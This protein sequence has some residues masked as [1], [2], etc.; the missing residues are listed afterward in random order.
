MNFQ[1]LKDYLDFYL[2][3]LGIPGSDTVIYKDHEQ[4]F[5]YQSGYD[6]L[7]FRTPVRSNAL[8]HVYSISKISTAVAATQLIERGELLANDPVYA[9]I[10]EFKNTPVKVMRPDGSFDLRPGENTMQIKH[11]LSM[12]AGMS[13]N[14]NSSGIL[15]VKERTE[16]R[17]PTLET[18]RAMAEEP[19]DFEPGTNYQYSLCLDV[20]GG[21]V[22]LVSGMSLGEYMKKNIFDPLGMTQ[23]SFKLTDERLDMMA[24]KYDYDPERRC[25]VEVPKQENPYVIGTEY[26]SGGAG[27]ISSV[28][29]QILLADALANGGMGRSGERILSRYGIDLMR[30]NLLD[31]KM[32]RKLGNDMP[33]NV[34][35]GYGYGV[36]TNLDP[37]SCGNIA[38]LGQFGWDGAKLCVMECDPE[39]K[40]A[41]FHAEHMGGLHP[42]VIPRLR[43]LIYSCIGE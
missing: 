43:N 13:Y 10:P 34:G 23:T 18:V 21:I 11:L 14:I 32:M 41:F 31:A 2:P 4:I 7:R 26:E 40:I 39:N 30:S 24:T 29:D 8:Y 27:L 9:Y 12:T 19:L 3:M 15:R 20:V 17:C 38:P 33:A 5:R 1:P 28:D 36:R 16:G 25:A 37:A 22:E 35:Y 42:V 6:S